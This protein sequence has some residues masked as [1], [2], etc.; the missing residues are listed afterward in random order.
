MVGVPG[1]VVY[2]AGERV[3]PLDHN[4]LPDSEAQ[5][6]RALLDRIESLENQMKEMQA[7]KAIEVCY[8]MEA[9]PSGGLE[10]DATLLSPN[11]GSS[12]DPNAGPNAGPNVECSINL[13]SSCCN[14]TDKAINEFLD[15]GG[16]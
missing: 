11:V 1:R 8:A 13:T 14:L 10:S 9:V 12:T 4:R 5:V 2:R 3:E 6:I 16:I 7:R 15:G